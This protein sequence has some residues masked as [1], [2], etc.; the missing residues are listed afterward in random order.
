MTIEQAV[1]QNLRELPPEQQQEVLNF[2]QSLKQNSL[3][4][5]PRSNLYGLWSDLDIEITE[6]DIAEIRQEMW[7]NFPK[8]FPL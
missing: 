4:P 8:E 2:I 7:G 3:S 1:L 5:Q 6:A